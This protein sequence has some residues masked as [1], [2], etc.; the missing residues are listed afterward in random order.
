M[1]FLLFMKV[2]QTKASKLSGSEYSEVYP[3]ALSIYK[4]LKKQS[5]RRPYIRSPYFD[6]DKIFLDYFWEHLH[7]KVWRDRVRRLKYYPAALDLI[8]HSKVE[9]HS[10]ENPN[11]TREILHR[12]AGLTSEKDL[13]FVQIKEDK[14]TNQKFF[15]SVFPEELP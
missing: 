7:H 15:I 4:K 12:F 14:K 3:K 10:K 11:K 2:Y 1:P 13:F 5:K 8:E 9:P 6:K